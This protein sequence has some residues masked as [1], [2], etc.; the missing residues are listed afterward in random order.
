MTK[1]AALLLV[2][3]CSLCSF[4]FAQEAKPKVS[5]D[6]FFNYVSFDSVDL[7]P[8]GNS[9]LITTHRADWDQEIFRKDL[10][11]YRINP[12]GGSLISLTHSGRDSRPQWSPD[13]QWIGFLSER[14]I[15]AGKSGDSGDKYK[16]ISQLYVISASGGEA[17]PVTSAGDDVHAFAWSADSK[18]LYFATRQP[19]SKQQTDEHKKE[20]KDSV[21]YRGD[22]RGDQVFQIALTDALAHSATMGVKQAPDKESDANLTPGAKTIGKTPWHIQ[23]LVTSGDGKRLAFATTSVSERQEFPAEFE[24]FVIELA[25]ASA[26]VA[27][28]QVTHNEAFEANLKWARDNRHLFFTV[29]QGSV[30]GKY[31]DSQPR[32]YAVDTDTSETQRWAADFP[33]EIVDYEVEPDGTLAVSARIGTEVQMYTLADGK[34]ALAKQNGSPGYYSNLTGAKE[35]KRFAFVHSSLQQPQEVY[36]ADSIATLGQARPITTF[37]QLFTERDLP[38]GKPYRWKSDDGTSVEGML[39]YPPGKF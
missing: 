21:L 2:L 33:G 16:E 23:Q 36:V 32:L 15:G 30:E 3:G 25:N 1:K 19:W 6:E 13:G 9:V 4:V 29:G 24:V 7:S 39:M 20:W 22:E 26:D 31:A 37:N 10:W 14:K 12:N 5:L 28:K 38:Q 27:P 11:L 18:Q 35:G 17:I 34:A 8:D